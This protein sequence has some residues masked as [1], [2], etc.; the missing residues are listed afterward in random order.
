MSE[1]R[2]FMAHVA[3]IH[4]KK[5]TFCCYDDCPKKYS[6]YDKYLC[7]AKLSPKLTLHDNPQKE[8]NMTK[9]QV[10]IIHKMHQKLCCGCKS[11]AIIYPFLN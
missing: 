8:I 9:Y 7:F 6:N 3:E 10:Q 11:L 4:T 1:G 5:K 2:V